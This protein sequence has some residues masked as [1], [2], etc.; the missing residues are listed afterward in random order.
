MF[1]FI[2]ESDIANIDAAYIAAFLAPQLS[3][4]TVPVDDY[5]KIKKSNYNYKR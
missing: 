3:K 4:A 1:S 5:N 2:L